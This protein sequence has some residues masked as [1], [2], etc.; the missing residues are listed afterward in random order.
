[1]ENSGLSYLLSSSAAVAPGGGAGTGDTGDGGAAA[2]VAAF[3][4]GVG[5]RG[6]VAAAAG[7]GGG[8]SNARKL[9]DLRRMYTLFSLVR[10]NVSW[11]PPTGD[12]RERMLPPL[13]VL[14][15]VVAPRRRRR[16]HPAGGG[17]ASRGDS[18]A[19][20]A[21]AASSDPHA[22]PMP[23]RPPAPRSDSMKAHVVAAGRAL[24]GDAQ[25]RRDPVALI[26]GLADLRD[27]FGDVQEAAFGDDKD[28]SRALKE[29]R[30]SGRADAGRRDD[31]ACRQRLTRSQ[32]PRRPVPRPRRSR[33]S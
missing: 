23:R 33:R 31:D 10:G 20:V 14:R 15:C 26:Q 29:V 12:G 7:A 24:V 27:K 28:F 3:S 18:A 19:Q 4:S 2:G 21:R 25:A 1:M 32:R 16:C 8:S 6:G 22:P 13:A 30:A 9:G 5:G 17:A 11:R